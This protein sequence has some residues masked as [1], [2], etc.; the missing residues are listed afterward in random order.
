MQQEFWIPT[1]PERLPAAIVTGDDGEPL[2]V[3]VEIRNRP[4]VLQ[5]WRVDVGRVPL[6]LLDAER[7]ENAR[8]DRWITARLYVERPAGSAGAVRAA[9]A[10]RHAGA[11]GDGDRPRRGASERGPRGARPA[12]AGPRADRSRR[13]SGEALADVKAPNGLHDPHAGSGRQRGVS[14]RE[15]LDTLDGFHDGLGMDERR[16][17]AL[18]RV[19]PDD[20]DEPFGVTPLGLRR[21]ARPTA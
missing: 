7:P 2:T 9:G 18:G 13:A 17:L 20:E 19:H 1:F 14:A 3:T 16:F 6:Y 12:G 10:G 8:V 11:P 4:V 15:V 5:I 21:A